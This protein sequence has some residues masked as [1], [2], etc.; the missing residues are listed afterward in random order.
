[1]QFQKLS[2]LKDLKMKHYRDVIVHPIS[3][4]LSFITGCD[5]CGAIGLKSSD[6]LQVPENIVGIVTTRVAVLEVMTLGA[7]VIGV[8]VPIANEPEPTGN[9][10][11]QGVH[12]CL[13]EFEL[14]IPVLT[15]M[16]KNMKTEMTAVGVVVNGL[17]EDVKMHA[18][19]SGDIIYVVGRPSVG[20]EV[21]TYAKQLLNVKSVKSLLASNDVKEILPVGSQGI[22]GEL[23]KM[24]EYHGRAYELIKDGALDVSKSCGPSSVAIVIAKA[25]CTLE[26]DIPVH[27]LGVIV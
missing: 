7:K 1:M 25:D 20:E 8:T 21:L 4:D 6:V 13:K 22:L 15:S 19:E 18:F 10:I 3:D 17:V 14:D 11:L 27:K 16:E 12:T 24:F 23:N 2:L 9:L 26:L 5:S